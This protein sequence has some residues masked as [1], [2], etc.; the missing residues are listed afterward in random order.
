MY[1]QKRIITRIGDTYE[2]ID[3]SKTPK[4]HKKTHKCSKKHKNDNVSVI[5]NINPHKNSKNRYKTHFIIDI[6]EEEVIKNNK[7]C[8]NITAKVID[9][10]N[11]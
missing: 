3:N 10:N 8:Y 11:K 9:I 1:R 7:T 4:K 5:R 6:V 2:N